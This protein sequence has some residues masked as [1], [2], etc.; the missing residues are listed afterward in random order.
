M[1][2]KL[3]SPIS[4][5]ASL[6][7][8][9][10][11]QVYLV[12]GSIRALLL[13]DQPKDYDLTTDATPA[14]LLDIFAAYK[15]SKIGQVFGTVLVV[16]EHSPVEITTM[17]LESS[18]RQHRYPEKVVFTSSILADLARRDFT[19][20]A[21]AWPVQADFAQADLIDPYGGRRD[22]ARRLIRAVGQPD[23]RL[24]E[25][26]LRILRA[27]RFA[28]GL[29]FA[30]EENTAR[31][32]HSQAYL[33][34]GLARERILAEMRQIFTAPH[35][36]LVL[37]DYLY[38]FAVAIPQL[39]PLCAADPNSQQGLLKSVSQLPPCFM[40]RLSA[41]LLAAARLS[42]SDP[43]DYALAAWTRLRSDR[44]TKE[45]SQ[46][47]LKA[48]ENLPRPEKRSVKMWLKKTQ[49][50]IA[51]AALILEKSRVQPSGQAMISQIEEQVDLILEAGECFRLADLAV[52]GQDLVRL[53]QK[54]GPALGR[55]LDQLLDLVILEKLPNEKDQLLQKA[56]SLLAQQKESG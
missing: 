51:R 11:H 35:L 30:L 39:L 38:V 42:S 28:A 26:A 53:G 55:L 52:S 7:L 10:Q 5:A 19:I 34:A 37:G 45:D 33:L 43:I 1:Q 31:A 14:Q 4:L 32:M 22:L 2:I 41:L 9:H 44:A 46:A 17:R 6:L 13:G 54:T 20:N 15:T 8:Q 56:A 24:Q 29:G 48:R 16:I 40:L 12:G 3:P 21:M 25:D 36:E 49:P 18:Y 50:Q 47:V 27:L 23:Q